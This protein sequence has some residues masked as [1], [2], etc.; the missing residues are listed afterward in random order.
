MD[1]KSKAFRKALKNFY[2]HTHR[3][4]SDGLLPSLQDWE[5]VCYDDNDGYGDRCTEYG[6]LPDWAESYTDE[7]LEELKKDMWC[8]VPNVPW[9]CTGAWFT[10]W[11]NFH[12]NPNG[13]ISYT[14]RK[15]VD[16]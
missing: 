15:A 16:C 14:H 5:R 10:Q 4:E 7:E 1:T 13:K 6:F 3:G 11:I 9:D 8:R 2:K 12:R